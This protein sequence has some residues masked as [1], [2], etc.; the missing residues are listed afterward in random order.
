MSIRD[1]GV[2]PIKGHVPILMT[3]RE[4]GV[5][6]ARV[7]AKKQW[8]CMKAKVVTKEHTGGGAKRRGCWMQNKSKQDL[9]SLKQSARATGSHGQ[10]ATTKGSAAAPENV[11]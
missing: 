8:D 4:E 10:R 7:L 9:T 11:F 5:M 6:G 1:K 2:Q 3:N